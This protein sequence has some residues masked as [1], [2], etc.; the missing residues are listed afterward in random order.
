M[1]LSSNYIKSISIAEYLLLLQPRKDLSDAIMDIKQAFYNKY[2]APEAN[3]SQAA[4]YIGKI[5]TIHR[6]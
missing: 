2:K 1:P 6:I 4:Y 5:C 3:T